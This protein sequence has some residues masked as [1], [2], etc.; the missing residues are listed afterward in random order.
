[1]IDA[2]VS[3]LGD[4]GYTSEEEEIFSNEGDNLYAGE[5]WAE[6][7]ED[8]FWA[9]F[10]NVLIPS[11]VTITVAYLSVY[12]GG[13]NVGNKEQVFADDQS[14][15]AAPTTYA[16]HRGRSRTTAGS[17]AWEV[18]AGTNEWRNSPSIVDVIQELVDSYDYSAGD[19]AIQILVDQH[20]TCTDYCG[21]GC[22]S[23][24]WVDTVHA[25]KLYIEWV[26]T[27]GPLPRFHHC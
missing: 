23:Y 11:G 24:D 16:D 22:R 13:F 9:R 20:A 8:Q 18:P 7:F 17:E 19:H 6:G 12:S 5:R 3:V 4:D 1:M 25:P 15:P 10:D 14:D 26:R 27:K 21:F 2:Q